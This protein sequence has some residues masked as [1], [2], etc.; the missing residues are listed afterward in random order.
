M[1]RGDL[2]FLSLRGAEQWQHRWKLGPGSGKKVITVTLRGRKRAGNTENEITIVKGRNNSCLGMTNHIKSCAK[3]WCVKYQ[4][5]AVKVEC[6]WYSPG[7]AYLI[8][9]LMNMDRNRYYYW[10]YM[11]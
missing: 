2:A 8:L 10:I 4:G 6:H 7:S 9:N 11:I 5:L 1:N 3:K